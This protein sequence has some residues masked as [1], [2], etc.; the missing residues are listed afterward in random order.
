M[1]NLIRKLLT[2]DWSTP[3]RPK[4]PKRKW[5]KLANKKRHSYA[6]YVKTGQHSCHE[7]HSYYLLAAHAL[8][9]FVMEHYLVL[10]TLQ[11][12]IAVLLYLNRTCLDKFT[13]IIG[14]ARVVLV[15]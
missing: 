8:L 2:C 7:Y 13:L 11:T 10:L 6:D 15:K 9:G 5:S 12:L 14:D 3:A 1:L 4:F